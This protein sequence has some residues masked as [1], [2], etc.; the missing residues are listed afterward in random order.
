M[1]G[2][3]REGGDWSVVGEGRGVGGGDVGRG[4]NDGVD[5]ELLFVDYYHGGGEP[6]GVGDGRG[7]YMGCGPFGGLFVERVGRVLRRR[8]RVAI[9]TD[10]GD[11]DIWI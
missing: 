10:C 3:G 7:I 11:L 1:W 4:R 5:H 8:E 9:E 6:G 2:Q